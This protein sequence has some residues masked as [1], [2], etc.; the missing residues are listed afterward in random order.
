MKSRRKTLIE[1]SKYLSKKRRMVIYLVPF[2]Y[3][4]QVAATHTYCMEGLCLFR[5]RHRLQHMDEDWHL[6]VLA[7]VG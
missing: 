6:P 1:I 2:E 7:F 5:D 3:R 4:I